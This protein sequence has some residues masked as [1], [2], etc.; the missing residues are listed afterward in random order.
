MAS[1]SMSFPI[2][3][4]ISP[5]LGK[6]RASAANAGSKVLSSSTAT[7]AFPSLSSS[8]SGRPARVAATLSRSRRIDGLDRLPAI[9]WVAVMCRQESEIVRTEIGHQVD[10]RRKSAIDRKNRPFSDAGKFKPGRL[11]GQ[12]NGSVSEGPAVSG[13]ECEI[14]PVFSNEADRKRNHH[15]CFRRLPRGCRDNLRAFQDESFARRIEAPVDRYLRGA[16]L[17]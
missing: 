11:L 1:G 16:G 6:I 2:S 7:S 8:R 14:A 15:R 13:L 4:A 3:R 10:R 12:H 17:A 5:S 9:E